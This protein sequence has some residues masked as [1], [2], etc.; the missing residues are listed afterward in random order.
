MTELASRALNID[1]TAAD[2][3]AMC[4]KHSIEI[5]A[6]ETLHSGG[7]R[8]VMMNMDDTNVIHRAFRTKLLKE[9]VVRTHW[10]RNR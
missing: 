4:T 6:I 9:R 10:L 7:T 1:A 3:S 2:V 5:S 8:V